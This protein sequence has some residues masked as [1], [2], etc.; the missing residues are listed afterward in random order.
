VPEADKTIRTIAIDRT[1]TIKFKLPQE[2]K[3]NDKKGSAGTSP[4]VDKNLA[5]IS[6]NK[7]EKA[8]K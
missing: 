6:S 2:E 4:Q 5:P 3:P 1:R 7:T 8:K